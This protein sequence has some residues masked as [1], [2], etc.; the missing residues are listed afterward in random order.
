MPT[1]DAGLCEPALVGERTRNS[2]I[3]DDRLAV[4][5]Q[6]VLGLDVPMDDAVPVRVVERECRLARDT[7]RVG[8]RKLP[9]ARHS[10]AK[11]FALDER[12]RVPEQPVRGPRIV[13]AQDVRMLQIGGEL[14]LLLEPVRAECRAEVR[15]EDFERDR[16]VVVRVDREVDRRH[17]AVPELALDTVSGG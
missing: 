13:H 14:D 11:R 5:Q 7:H 1:D 2:E 4:A 9:F 3:G 15:V 16:P 17:A 6:N 10:I 8:N 12:H